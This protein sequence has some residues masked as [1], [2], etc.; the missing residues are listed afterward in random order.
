M[1]HISLA[2]LVACLALVAA[3][4]GASEEPP[5]TSEA[6]GDCLMCHRQVTPA[7]VADWEKSAHAKT[8]MSRALG[9][10]KI[11]SKV[12]ADVAPEKLGEVS[13]GCAE[14]HVAGGEPRKGDFDHNG[15]S[16]RLVVTPADCARCHPAEADEYSMNIMSRAHG[17]LA[18][19]PLYMDLANNINATMAF[20]DGK[21]KTKP[22]NGPTSA[23]SCF[24]CHGTALTV[25]G[26]A[27]RDTDLGEMEF[28]VFSGWPNDGVGRVN[29]DGSMG[30]CSPC[31]PRHA[32]SMAQARSPY[33]CAN[34]HKGPDV[35]AFKVYMVSKHGAL[36]SGS[37]DGWDMAAVPWTAGEDFTAPTC[38]ACHISLVAKGDG[39]VVQKRTH[40]M[41]DRLSLRLFGPVYAVPHPKSP[42]TSAIVNKDGQ[43]LPATLGGELASEHLIGRDEMK[44][45]RAAM[46]SVCQSCHGE[47]WVGGHFERLDNTV[48]ETND[49]TR[50]ASAMLG[51]GWK[52]GL[53][54][55]PPASIFDEP[56]E[57]M[58][59]EHWLFYANSV[60]FASA[61][62]GA[63]Y[64]VF[65]DGRFQMTSNLLRM[66]AALVGGAGKSGD[67][68]G[69]EKKAGG[70]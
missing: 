21:L 67:G 33:A 8:T 32:F 6:T 50:A 40:R 9:K 68:G 65:A 64:G 63:D 70:Q 24:S 19:N 26:S 46:R 1:R 37:G 59:V 13:V 10:K 61:M 7:A 2:A 14:C 43:P 58:W 22:P 55:G 38:A 17:N 57:R 51:E 39:E 69:R 15:F 12:S 5:G 52:Q 11:E 35:P 18:N 36:Y 30:S 49:S 42:D 60:R 29:P 41:N 27:T 25:T 34:C 54:A 16:V 44:K 47:G 48:A 56:F 4:A 45:R 62:A 23:E 53:A 31:H 3:F 28:P 66:E 20:E